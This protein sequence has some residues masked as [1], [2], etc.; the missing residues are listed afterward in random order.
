MLTDT[1]RRHVLAAEGWLELGDPKS[2]FEELDEVDP[3]NRADPFVLTVRFGTLVAAERWESAYEVADALTR[4]RPRR[5]EPFIWRAFVARQMPGRG[6]E[7]ARELLLEVVNKFPDSPMPAFNLACYN[8][9]LG[10]LDEARRW[11]RAALDI[12]DRMGEGAKWK[13]QA[14]N[15][16][17]LDPLRRHLGLE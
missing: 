5:V 16:A 12:A 9:A 14:L 15:D 3:P 4:M 11:L 10:R 6:P 2:A 7:R 1:D 8:S 17:D 13:L